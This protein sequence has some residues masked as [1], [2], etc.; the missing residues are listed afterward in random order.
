MW[1]SEIKRLPL[2]IFLL[3]VFP[4]LALLSNNLGETD[5]WVVHRPLIVSILIGILF[6]LMARLLVKNRQKASLWTSFSVAMFFSYGHIYQI[7]EDVQIFGFLIGRHRY[8][9]ILWGALFILGTWFIF[10]KMRELNEI[11]LILNMVSL[12]LVLFQIG[13]IASYQ[14]RKRISHEQAQAAISDTLLLPN[15]PE[16]MP[17]VYLIILDMY[18]R[19]DA[20]DAHYNY[21]NSEFI[22]QLEEIDFYV[23]DCARSNYAATALSLASQLNMEYLD[24]LIDDVNLESTSYLIR[25]STVRMAFEEIG[26]TSIAFNTGFGW[27]NV[28]D[29]DIYL[30][31][32]LDPILWYIDPFEQL[33]IEGTLL[34]PLFDYYIS[35]GLGE[36]RYFDTPNEMKA[37]LTRMVLDHLKLIPQMSGPKFVY[38]HIM[39][40]HPPHVF[41]SDGSVNLQASKHSDDKIEFQ[42]QLDYLNPQIIEIVKN[43]IDNSDPSPIIILEG[44]H[45]LFDFERTSILNALYFPTSSDKVFYPQISLVNTFRLLFNEYFGT[46]YPLLDDSSYDRLGGD[47]YAYVPHPHEEWNPACIP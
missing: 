10:R 19:E 23:A 41:N 29:S 22:S 47:N 33:F 35:L 1:N 16:D 27:A 37:Q 2:H 12:I 42:I 8:L 21:D 5:L 17:D 6:F 44:D 11:I 20:L 32:P 30:D 36:I 15:D 28:G 3:S 14:I 40:P 43:I 39:M 38:A 9:V 31:K 18:G 25:N 13:Q 26:Y 45:G 24:V 34:R 4:S 46:D 7:V